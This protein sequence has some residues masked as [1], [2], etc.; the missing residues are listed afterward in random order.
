MCLFSRF[1]LLFLS[2][3]VTPDKGKKITRWI[4][5]GVP[6]EGSC[7]EVKDR[8]QKIYQAAGCELEKN[9]L[10]VAKECNFAVKVAMALRI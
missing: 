1:S 9:K 4:F 8:A 10:N 5:R 6:E 2:E 3:C 7:S